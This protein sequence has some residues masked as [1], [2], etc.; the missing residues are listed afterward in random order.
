VG[1][2]R[3][4]PHVRDIWSPQFEEMLLSN[5]LVEDGKVYRRLTMENHMKVVRA[6]YDQK[7]AELYPRVT[8][9]VLLVPAHRQPES[10]QERAWQA[11][12]ERGVEA[13]RRLLPDGRLKAMEDTPHDVP[14]FRPEH[15]AKAIAEF[16]G[17]LA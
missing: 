5:F 2:A 16:A 17:D 8:A 12:R 14:V 11:A 7:A 3:N 4:W 13:A 1:F 10:E 9:P 6:I 15:L